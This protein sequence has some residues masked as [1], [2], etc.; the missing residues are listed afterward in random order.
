[1]SQ[2]QT[3]GGVYEDESVTMSPLAVS[4]GGW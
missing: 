2:V 4:V 1:V 3:F